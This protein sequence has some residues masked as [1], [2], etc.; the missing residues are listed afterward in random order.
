M[1]CTF[2]R[3]FREIIGGETVFQGYV[4]VEG[5][6]WLVRIVGLGWISFDFYVFGGCVLGSRKVGFGFLK[7]RF[8]VQEDG[9]IFKYLFFRDSYRGEGLGVQGVF[10][11]LFFREYSLGEDGRSKGWVVFIG[12][13]EN[14]I[15]YLFWVVVF[16]I[17]RG[18]GFV[19][20]VFVRG[21]GKRRVGRFF[22]QG[23]AWEWAVGSWKGFGDVGRG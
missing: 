8:V 12:G 1:C 16:F 14:K 6:V 22:C 23:F 11:Y 10:S 17:K 3:I 9:V 7:K 19:F 13:I 21:E 2:Y 15:E 5:G 18:V 4:V 20:W